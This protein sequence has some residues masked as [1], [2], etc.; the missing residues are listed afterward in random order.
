MTI[1]ENERFCSIL[2]GEEVKEVVFSPHGTYMV[3]RPYVF[4]HFC[5]ATLGCS[6]DECCEFCLTLLQKGLSVEGT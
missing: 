6:K 2:F 4:S 5:K 3:L 1:E